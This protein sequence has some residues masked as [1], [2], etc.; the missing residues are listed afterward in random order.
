MA[1]ISEKNTPIVAEFRANG[2]AVGGAFE[3]VPL[4]LLHSTGA[5]SG[6]EY[7]HPLAYL[8]DGRQLAVFGTAGGR[9]NNPAWYYNVIAHP[10]VTVEAGSDTFNATARV[11]TGDERQALWK[12]QVEQNPA[13]ADYEI[14]RAHV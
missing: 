2:G 7:I 13:F 4:L 5:K 10:G 9:P 11:A 8:E 3:N 6:E 12:R 1:S 14:G